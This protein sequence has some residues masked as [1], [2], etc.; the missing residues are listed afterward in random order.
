MQIPSDN[1]DHHPRRRRLPFRWPW[2]VSIRSRLL[3]AFVLLVLLPATIIS[4]STVT[5]GKRH[6]EQQVLIHLQSVATLKDKQ[7]TAWLESMRIHLTSVLYPHRVPHLID[8]LLEHAPGSAAYRRAYEELHIQFAQM[9]DAT[10]LFE[11][12]LLLDRQGRVLISTERNHE[13]QVHATQD[14]FWRGLRGPYMQ[15][16]SSSTAQGRSSPVVVSRPVLD[17]EG[18]VRGVLAGRA[19]SAKL[20]EIM[21]QRVG[22]GT[23]GETY[24]VG[25]NFLLLTESRFE[26]RDEHVL[27]LHTPA[28]ESVFQTRTNH[29]GLY[30]NY[31]HQQ[32]IGVYHWLPTLQ[33]V[34]VAEQEEAEA[35]QATN[36][37]LEFNMIFAGMAVCVALL[38]AI[39]VW[40]S[41]ATPLA[42]L[43]QTATHIA[44]GDLD[45]VARI[46]RDDEVG[47][48]AQA[49]NSMTAR[50]RQV[51]GNLENYVG[52]LEQAE[53]E[54]RDANA[55]LARDVVE[56]EALSRLSNELQ[57]CQTPDEAYASSVPLLREVFVARPG[58]FYR[59]I[60]GAPH[61]ELVGKWG[62]D[63]PAQVP[64]LLTECPALEGKR[65]LITERGQLTDQCRACMGDTSN[66]AVCVQLQ[67]GG[68]QFGVLHLRVGTDTHSE[69]HTHVLPLAVRV[70]DLL[71]LA[72]ANLHLRANLREEA[73]RDSLT[74]LFNRRYLNEALNQKLSQA[75]RHQRT[76]GMILLDIDHFKHINDTYGHDAG[77]AV[78]RAIGTLL[79]TNLR[80]EDTACRFGGE[81]LLLVLP[82]IVEGDALRRSEELRQRINAMEITY[83]DIVLPRI[84]VSMGIAIFPH[85]EQTHDR[86]MTAADQALYH[87]KATGRNRVC[88][89]QQVRQRCEQPVAP[90]SRT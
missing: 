15:S 8:P 18:N 42:N 58:A 44:A 53:A 82:E 59:R 79:R 12:V 2:P 49:F 51:I 81:E 33:M 46:E 66:L 5:L 38:S 54:V 64:P 52:E 7:I 60:A 85:H 74:G 89:A 80:A 45:T 23:T 76:V 31:R 84:T 86:L 40:R 43:A 70:A 63:A 20:N 77:D 37:T 56:Q 47:A 1:P 41:I 4:V 26:D 75:Q 22:L 13:G 28:L 27:R 62:T 16:L 30:E 48:L 50:L 11:E 68:E 10:E 71:A 73:I 55:R 14:Y 9:S 61:L 19:S 87:A 67:T 17:M 6:G 21:L 35:F 25:Q 65:Y 72:L 78:L 34:L 57:R 32:V 39:F 90:P 83:G 24:L 88:V 36:A 3:I 69:L 29:S